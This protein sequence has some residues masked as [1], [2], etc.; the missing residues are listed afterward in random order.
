MEVCT[1]VPEDPGNDECRDPTGE[2]DSGTP[3]SP[4]EAPARV[5]PLESG[6]LRASAPVPSLVLLGWGGLMYWSSVGTE[7]WLNWECAGPVGL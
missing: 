7:G 1:D 5:G 6:P 3:W 4:A 2:R